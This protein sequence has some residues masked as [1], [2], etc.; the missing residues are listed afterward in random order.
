[1]PCSNSPGRCCVAVRP[2]SF[3]LGLGRETRSH[4][5]RRARGPERRGYVPYRR[6]D[7][8]E[9]AQFLGKGGGRDV[10]LWPPTTRTRPP[11][12]SRPADWHFARRPSPR[13]ISVVRHRRARLPREDQRSHHP[14]RPFGSTGAFRR[15]TS[16]GRFA[17]GSAPRGSALR[18]GHDPRHRG[19]A[20]A[21]ACPPVPTRQPRATA[22]QPCSSVTATACSPSTWQP[23][24]RPRSSLTAGASR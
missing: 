17:P 21:A 4:T 14:R 10:A 23:V 13:S 16:A 5:P 7:R 3:V 9:I 18:R 15:S 8:A 24:R 11:W 19:R 6:L 22:V 12:R 1:M 2:H 20:S